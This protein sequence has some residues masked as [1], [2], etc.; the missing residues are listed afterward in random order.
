MLF[1]STETYKNEAIKHLEIAL[2]YWDE[3]VKISS[4]IYKEMPLVHFS[5]QKNISPEAK[6]KLRFHWALLRD[7]VAKDIEMARNA[8]VEK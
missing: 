3:V 7:E 8:V 4:P 5:E 2:N 6:A 1:R